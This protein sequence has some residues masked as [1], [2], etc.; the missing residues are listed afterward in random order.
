MFYSNS[1]AVIIINESDIDD[2]FES[3]YTIII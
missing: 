2:E 3:I 1:K